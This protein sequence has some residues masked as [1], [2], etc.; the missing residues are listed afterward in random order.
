MPNHIELFMLCPSIRYPLFTLF[1]V[2]GLV[3]C[4]DSTDSAIA[5]AVPAVAVALPQPAQVQEQRDY[6]GRFDVLDRVVLRSRVTGYIDAV[7]FKGG[8]AVRKDDV[9]FVIDQRPFKLVQQQAE[10]EHHAAL[11]A[12]V[13]AKSEQQRGAELRELEA[14]S[15]EVFDQRNQALLL[16]DARL[17]Q[18]KVA[19]QQAQLNLD[20]CLVKSPI[21]GL[22]GRRLVS[23]GNLVQAGGAPLANIVASAPLY[24]NF[25][26]NAQDALRYQALIKQDTELEKVS[27]SL[28]SKA[29]NADT[30]YTATFDFMDIETDQSTGTIAARVRLDD[31]KNIAD[32]GLK[33]GMFAR[34]KIPL[35]KPKSAYLV[36]DA[37]IASN[38]NIKTLMVIENNII[39]IKPVVTGGMREGLRVVW[40]GISAHENIVS[41][42]VQNLRPGMPATP[43][44]EAGEE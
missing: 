39:A 38:Q 24:F 12:Q 21:T 20:Y 10:A 23:E 27:I 2:G 22:V 19:L 14:L 29:G 5:P 33:P 37:L 34:V 11:A 40:S 44:V 1:L 30:L 28:P 9:L 7:K 4:S 31:S 43:A 35:S 3:A 6:L 13:L 8:Q 26:L 25:E 32:Y 18:A 36:P 17:A 41:A 42:G 16:A 15:Q